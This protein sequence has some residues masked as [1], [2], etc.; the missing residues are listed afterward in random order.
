MQGP[1]YRVREQVEE[2]VCDARSTEGHRKV[3]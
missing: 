2:S 3:L 1:K